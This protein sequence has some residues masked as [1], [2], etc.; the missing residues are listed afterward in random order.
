[1]AENYHN[2]VEKNRHEV[3]N[4]LLSCTDHK[5]MIEQAIVSQEKEIEAFWS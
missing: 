4:A 3:A 2:L 1:M 5:E